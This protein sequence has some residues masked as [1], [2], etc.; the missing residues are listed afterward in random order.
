M[1]R[2][3]R[4]GTLHTIGAFRSETLYA[5]IKHMRTGKFIVFEGGEGCGKTT[6]LKLLAA[7]LR[8][9]RIK[10]ILTKEPGGT[11]VA[12]KIRQIILTKYS[13]PT[14][15]RTELLLFLA[16]RA[17]HVERK[18][19][20]A[21]KKGYW[22]LC[23]RFSGSTLAYQIGARGLRPEALIKQ[24]DAYARQDLQPDLVIYLDL[25]PQQGLARKIS[26]RQ[27]FNRLDR[28]KIK[29]H[30]AVRRY[31]LRLA[32]QGHWRKIKASGSIEEVAK[33]IDYAIKN[34]KN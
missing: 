16:S 18:I 27:V 9:R 20:P 2:P 24:M 30:Q 34:R 4:G 1:S 28:E 13:E 8:R 10:F 21:L 26:N 6:Q 11:V 22:V 31:F 32:R 17:Q 23:D 5:I 7:S 25:D 29:F 14:A 19:K 3:F 12:D 15:A 33:K